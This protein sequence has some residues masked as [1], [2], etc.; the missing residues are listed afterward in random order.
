MTRPTLQPSLSPSEFRR[1]RWL[2]T[3]LIDFCAAHDLPTNGDKHTLLRRVATFL[4][5]AQ[6]QPD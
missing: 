3:E 6:G 2:K 5:K 4:A 1:H